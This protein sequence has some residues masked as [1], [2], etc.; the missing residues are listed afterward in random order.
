M[1][2]KYI[3]IALT[4]LTQIFI[5]NIN[6]QDLYEDELETVYLTKFDKEIVYT[7]NF[8]AY[9][10]MLVKQEK[11]KFAKEIKKA[12]L[13]N[14]SL[15][16][17][18]QLSNLELAEDKYIKIIR[19]SANRSKTSHEFEKFL[20]NEIPELKNQIHED[21]NLNYLFIISRKNTFNGKIDALPS[22]L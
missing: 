21:K 7:N 11:L 19:R 5:N 20:I 10:D 6:G 2:T 3:I 17:L 8:L 22:V 9:N 16:F 14:N 18:S 4:T 1:K 12:K 13:K 15:L